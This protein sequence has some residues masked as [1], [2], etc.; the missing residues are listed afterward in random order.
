MMRVAFNNRA[1]ANLALL[2]V[3]FA[4]FSSVAKATPPRNTVPPNWEIEVLDPRASSDGRPAVELVPGG[5]HGELKVDIPPAILVHK[6]Y[7]SG[8]RSFQAQILPGGPCIVVANHPKNGERQYIDVVLPPGAPRVTY[9]A[10]SIDYDFG[11]RGVRVHFPPLGLSPYVTYRNGKTVLQTAKDVTHY[12][13]FR[14][15]MEKLQQGIRRTHEQSKTMAVGVWANAVDVSK[16][17]TLPASNVLQI[18]PFG[19]QLF[20]GDLENQLREGAAEYR[21]S[22]AAKAAE[23]ARAYEQQTIRTLR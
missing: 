12:D 7:Y 9:Y 14:G 22:H 2:L 18:L 8:H 5:K 3:V 1:A 19:K 10:H 4:C 20:G 21:R 11:H 13:H 17:V 6:Y 15:H 23:R 16:V